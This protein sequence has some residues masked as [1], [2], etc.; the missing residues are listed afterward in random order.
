[1]QYYKSERPEYSVGD[2]M[3]FTHDGVFHLFYLLDEGH[4]NHPIVGPL[5]GHQWAHAVSRDLKEWT[6]LPLALPLDFSKEG[7]NCT[8]SLVVHENQW[9]AFYSL[10]P[11]PQ[12]GEFFRIAKSAD[13]IHFNKES[14]T[15][16]PPPGYGGSFRDPCVFRD[17]ERIFHMLISTSRYEGS[18]DLGCL[19]HFTSNDLKDWKLC[20]PILRTGK[21]DVPE[22]SD[23][24]KWNGWYYLL[25]G[26]G[27]TTHYRMSRHP[28]GPWI[29]PDQDIPSSALTMVM[30]T[31]SWHNNRR[32]GVAWLPTRGEND[33][34]LFGGKAVFREMIQNEDGTLGTAFPL[35][36]QPVS[37]EKPIVLQF[38]EISRNARQESGTLFL[39]AENSL[40]TGYCKTL[41]GNYRLTTRVIQETA[42]KNFGFFFSNSGRS[43]LGIEFDPAAKTARINYA[44]GLEQVKVGLEQVKELTQSEFTLDIYVLDNV[45]DVCIDG[46]RTLINSLKK[47]HEREPLIAYAENGR[48]Q[49]KDLTVYPL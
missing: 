42:S 48:I 3:P 38:A 7:S 39:N 40:E 26:I 16:A 11:Y 36:M 32:I 49:F 10:R 29:A 37:S 44:V 15:M 8:G 30:K 5:G 20:E 6:H 18:L 43:S 1:M 41:P 24:F 45:I 17:E 47:N 34:I 14:G 35:E 22:C 19:G 25:F 46:K 9:Y 21:F 12:G 23:Y 4:H 33:Q 27:G 13:G 28:F 2:C 31:T